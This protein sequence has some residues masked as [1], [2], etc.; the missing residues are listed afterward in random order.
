MAFLTDSVFAITILGSTLIF[1]M[2]QD[3]SSR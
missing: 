3:W 1:F 2:V